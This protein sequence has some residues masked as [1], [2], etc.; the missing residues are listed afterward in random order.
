MSILVPYLDARLSRI[1][2]LP[3]RIVLLAVLRHGQDA[4][5]MGRE[6]QVRSTAKKYVKNDLNIRLRFE[7]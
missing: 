5:S 1:E 3:L 2:D 4:S 6:R 7:T